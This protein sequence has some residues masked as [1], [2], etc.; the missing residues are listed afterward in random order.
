[1]MHRCR[2]IEFLRANAPESRGIADQKLRQKGPTN[3]AAAALR[4]VI[5][6]TNEPES[7]C[8]RQVWAAWGSRPQVGSSVP[9]IPPFFPSGTRLIFL[10]FFGFYLSQIVA[11]T[12]EFYGI[13][14]LVGSCGSVARG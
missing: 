11:L 2:A 6:P 14:A 13:H 3:L 7:N 5:Y 8:G 9:G 12:R 10:I 4:F 1:M